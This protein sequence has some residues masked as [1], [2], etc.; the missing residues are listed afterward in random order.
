MSVVTKKK[1]M[2]LPSVSKEKAS[3]I[4]R[5]HLIQEIPK[6]FEIYD[7]VPFGIKYYNMSKE[8]CWTVLISLGANQLSASR[9]ICVSKKTGKIIY[10]G[11]T[12]D[13]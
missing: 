5:E 4:I 3:Q 6:E 12:N 8:P 9:M 13:E 11:Q 1:D 10:D 7:G 2:N